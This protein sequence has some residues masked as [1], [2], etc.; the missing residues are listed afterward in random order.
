MFIAVL[1]CFVKISSWMHQC[2]KKQWNEDEK[3]SYTSWRA[4]WSW[5]EYWWL[6]S[7]RFTGKKFLSYVCEAGKDSHTFPVICCCCCSSLSCSAICTNQPYIYIYIFLVTL[8]IISI[9][10][11]IYKEKKSW[12]MMRDLSS[13]K[14]IVV[15]QLY[16][17]RFFMHML[18]EVDHVQIS[19]IISLEFVL[20]YQ[21]F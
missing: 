17:L 16:F 15:L 5:R 20:I 13:Q 10:I 18:G 8:Y 1:P 9:S 7:M 19:G 6:E 4:V 11:Y 21:I 3:C 14:V 2:I 12:R